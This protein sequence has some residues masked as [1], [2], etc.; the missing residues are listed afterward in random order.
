MSSFS[1]KRSLCLLLTNLCHSK[2]NLFSL[3]LLPSRTGP[4]VKSNYRE[5]ASCH[6]LRV[7]A[8]IPF[9]SICGVSWTWLGTGG[10]VTKA[11]EHLEQCKPQDPRAS[12]NHKVANLV[13]KGYNAGTREEPDQC[14]NRLDSRKSRQEQHVQP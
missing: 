14:G 5:E 13:S 2:E 1:L 12:G 7:K 6:I 10:S 11:G 4:G 8:Q 9:L 3:K